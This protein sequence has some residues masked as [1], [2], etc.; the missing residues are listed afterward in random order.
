[1][2]TD[3]AFDNWYDRYQPVTN[4][5]NPN[6]TFSGLLFETYGQDWDHVSHPDKRSH[7]WT[8]VEGDEGLY[9]LSGLRYVNRIGFFIT[10]NAPEP[11]EKLVVAIKGVEDDYS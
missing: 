2:E 3:L 10:K 4:H 7:V 9:I 1:M 5:L 8:L 6:A 11:G